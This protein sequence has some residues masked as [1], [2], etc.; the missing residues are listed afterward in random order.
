MDGEG[1]APGPGTIAVVGDVHGHLQLA[2]CVLAR[3]QHVL[4]AKFEA[5]LLCGDV[6]T[7]T[8]FLNKGANGADAAPSRRQ[9]SSITRFWLQGRSSARL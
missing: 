7:F 5:V 1:T 6:G 8:E 4:G 3:W 9:A 2:L